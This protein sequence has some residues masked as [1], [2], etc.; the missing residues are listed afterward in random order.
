MS[1][2]NAQPVL[3]D[4]PAGTPAESL[5]PVLLKPVDDVVDPELSVVIPALNER[6]TIADTVDW[7]KEGFRKT[8]IVGEILIIDSSTDDTPQIAL[9]HGARVL[10]TPK[11]G[12]GRAY[13]DAMPHIRADYILMGDA[14]CTYDFRELGGFVEKFRAGF[15]FIMGSRFRGSI[16]NGAMPALHRY[17]GTPLTTWILNFLYSSRFTDIQCGL[18]GITK[19]ALERI[20]LQ[21][22]SWEYASEMVLKSAC[23]RLPTAEVPVRFLKDREGRS[24]HMK[25]SGLLE[26]WRA[27]W[28]NLRAMLVY[29]ADFFVLKP[30]LCLFVLGLLLALPQT[31][32]P[33]KVG[34]ITLS[35]YWG[36]VGMTLA[37]V[38]LQSFYLGCILQVVYHYSDRAVNRWLSLFSYTRA[39]VVSVISLI[40]GCAM[41]TP[42]V[43][44]YARGGMRLPAQAGPPNHLAVAGLLFMIAAFLTFD[45]TL[46]VQAAALYAGRTRSRA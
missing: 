34:P 37:A 45:S 42:L 33:V 10:R 40:A 41:A 13:I 36:L 25:R 35:L 16:E 24:S 32:G 46:A 6:L 18:R 3:D 31:F 11:R 39:I 30:G 43:I 14:D 28:V 4:V 7:C 21:S 8:G 27:G 29:H 22:Q 5:E 44:E 17:F 23:Y 15:E 26:P 20:E 9:A 2:E 38:G 12:L 19:A 1:A